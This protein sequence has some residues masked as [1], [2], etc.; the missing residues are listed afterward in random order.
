MA[1]ALSTIASQQANVTE[2]TLKACN[3]LFDYVGTY[4]DAVLKYMA[5]DMIFEM[6]SDASYLSKA[7]SPSP[8]GGNFYLTNVNGEEFRNDD[9]FT[10]L[11]IIKNIMAS[12]S[13]A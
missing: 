6:H 7:K 3:Q 12:S 13:E 10:L 2:A 9:V 11:S 8:P 1:T 4:P 5:G